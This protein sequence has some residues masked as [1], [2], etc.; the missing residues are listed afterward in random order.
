MIEGID[1]SYKDKIAIVV[2]GYNRIKAI[3]RLLACL[4][5]AEYPSNDIPLVISI[6]ASK[7]KEL[8][9]YVRE[10]QWHHGEKFVN[11][12]KERLGLKAHIF[13]CASLSSRFRAVILLE[14][15]LFLS[16]YF[17]RYVLQAVDKYE[18]DNRVAEI[19]LYT[20]EMN[21]YTGLPFYPLQNGSDTFLMQDVC[22]SG[23]CITDSMWKGFMDWYSKPENI[24]ISKIDMQPAI[25]SW[26][27]AW[28]K[29][30][31]AYVVSQNL[32]VVYPRAAVSTNFNDKG[33]HGVN[34][35]DAITQI[36]LS[37]HRT[38]YRMFDFDNL[39]KYDIYCNNEALYEWLSLSRDEVCLDLYGTHVNP[40]KRYILSTRYLPYKVLENYALSMKPIELN[41][42]YG[43]K[44]EG[45]FLYDT[46]V[47]EECKK[48]GKYAEGLINYFLHGFNK[49]FIV[50]EAIRILKQ[51]LRRK[52]HL[53]K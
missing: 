30:F 12:Q 41:I 53:K 8:Y 1:N 16:P 7:N 40:G 2:I 49:H 47:R 34:E 22:T 35:D 19:A 39:V 29:P 44:G 3:S 21:G 42:K 10:F 6:D 52:L 27:K 20:N 48:E 25:K 13:Q 36:N 11:I 31:N 14:D 23:E 33:T 4:N 50:N 15:D 37:E 18:K 28:S 26:T 45:I 46:M 17:Y 9:N 24:D 43:I 5:N 51:A 38:E 32:H